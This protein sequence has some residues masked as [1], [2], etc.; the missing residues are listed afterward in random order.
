M[1][2][3]RADSTV[4]TALGRVGAF[5]RIAFRS[6]LAPPQHLQL[7]P[8]TLVGAVIRLWPRQGGEAHGFA[9]ARGSLHAGRSFRVTGLGLGGRSTAH[10]QREHLRFDGA[11]GQRDIDQLADADFE[12]GLHPLSRHFHLAA[13]DGNGGERARLE[14]PH[15]P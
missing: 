2:E 12:S 13:A 1:A 9:M 11:I 4:S 10:G 15:V 3:A 8:L 7:A 5:L 6:I 14:Q